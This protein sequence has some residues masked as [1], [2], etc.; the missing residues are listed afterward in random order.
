MRSHRPIAERFGVGARDAPGVVRRRDADREERAV[1]GIGGRRSHRPRFL[2]FDDRRELAFE[3]RSARRV[4]RERKSSRLRG[5]AVRRPSASSRFAGSTG[6]DEPPGVRSART[7]SGPSTPYWPTPSSFTKP[8][9]CAP[10]APFGYSR[11]GSISKPRPGRCSAAHP[12]RGL[13]RQP[14]PARTTT[15][16]ASERRAQDVGPLAEDRSDR[17][18][19]RRPR[20]VAIAIGH[21]S[22]IA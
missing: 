9:T 4:D 22:G 20:V 13:L 6:H 17:R 10:T 12:D 1:L 19:D 16:A 14:A 21:E 18:G 11:F 8:R 2:T 15:R 5:T 3:P 7:R